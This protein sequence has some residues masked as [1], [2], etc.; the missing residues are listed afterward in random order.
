MF[1]ELAHTKLNAYK[2]TTNLLVDCYKFTSHLP[3]EEKHNIVSQIKRAALSVH[4]NL[5]EGAARKSAAERRRFFEISRSSLVEI[6]AA[7]DA[8]SSLYNLSA[9]NTESL[10]TSIRDSYSLLTGLI[11]KT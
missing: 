4:L 5:A 10:G 2:S 8:T 9:I 6:D 1:L 3:L 7:L 11:N